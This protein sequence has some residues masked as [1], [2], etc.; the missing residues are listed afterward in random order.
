M[1]CFISIDM[2]EEV[3]EELREIQEKIPSDD[4]KMLLVDTEI[5]HL[6][7]RF[8]GEIDDFKINK[9]RDVLKSLKIGKFKARLGNVG[10]FPDEN[11]VRVV[12][13]SLQPEEKFKEISNLVEKELEGIE[14]IKK[15][16][17][18]ESHVTLARVKFVKNRKDFVEKLK[19]IKIQ[20]VEFSVDRIF[21]KKSTLTPEGP[22]YENIAEIKLN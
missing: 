16:E 3:R 2:P 18:F 22:V 19:K 4:V 7:L 9:I 8:L 17:R 5:L 21:L 11:F 1:R 20:P 10:I 14:G 15:E 12:W 6:T 13:I